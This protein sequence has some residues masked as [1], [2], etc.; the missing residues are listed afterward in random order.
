[1]SLII[2]SKPNLY[3]E[4]KNSNEMLESLRNP[5]THNTKKIDKT[6]NSSKPN[7]ND[8]Q[9]ED[10]LSDSTVDK[11]LKMLDNYFDLNS[12]KKSNKTNQ[13]K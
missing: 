11:A 10:E 13:N 5:P 12:K 2:P 1:M 8:A 4:N 9:P 3:I 6:A 7:T